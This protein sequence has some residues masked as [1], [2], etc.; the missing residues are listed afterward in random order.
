MAQAAEPPPVKLICGMISAKAELFDE[1]AEALAKAFGP[2]DLASEIMDFDFT[3]YYDEQMGS[4]LHRRFVA[5]AECVRPDALVE[6]KLATNAIEGEFAARLGGRPAR[7][8]NLD[9]GYLEP[10]K[11]V[12]ASMKNFS[13]RI[14]M[15]RGVYAE[16]TL[17]YR[18][19]RWEPL[20]WTFPDYASGRYETFLAQARERLMRQ[21]R[22]EVGP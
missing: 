3:H 17:L 9:V 12:L 21:T 14:Y 11:L 6:A 22:Q 18:R 16:V 1:A 4:P 15:G 10:S 19:G 5:F 2:V 7:P 20:A 8:I 13:H